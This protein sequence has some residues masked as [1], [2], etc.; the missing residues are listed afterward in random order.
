MNFEP[1]SITISIKKE[2]ENVPLA[3]QNPVGNYHFFCSIYNMNSNTVNGVK[4]AEPDLTSFFYKLFRIIWYWND[5]KY[6]QISPCCSFPLAFIGWIYKICLNFGI[7]TSYGWFGYNYWAVFGSFSSGDGNDYSSMVT[8]VYFYKI[9]S[10]ELQIM[11]PLLI[12]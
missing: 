5:M 10:Y 9:L 7:Y 6:D 12:V 3:D 4:F 8:Y 11:V 1:T 2:G